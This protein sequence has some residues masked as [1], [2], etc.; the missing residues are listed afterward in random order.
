VL[1]GAVAVAVVGGVTGGVLGA[2]S[3]SLL[4]GIPV[5]NQRV[6]MQISLP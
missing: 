1:G 5:E 2:Q 6:L 3:S 4:P